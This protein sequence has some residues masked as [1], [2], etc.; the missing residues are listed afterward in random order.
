MTQYR[1]SIPENSFNLKG[2]YGN[3][4]YDTRNNLTAYLNY[5]VSFLRGPHWLSNG[6]QLN[7]LLSF[8]GGQP[9]SVLTG[10]DSSGTNEGA[11]RATQVGNPV[12][13]VNRSLVKGAGSLQWITSNAFTTPTNAYGLLAR[14]SLYG[15]GFGDVDLSVFKTGH[16]TEHVTAQFRAE[17]FN[18]FNRTN[19]A[20]IDNSL[21]D[22]SSFGTINTTIGN[23]NGAPGIG[24][25][26]PYNTQF[27]L[28]VLF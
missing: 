19:L 17:M 4:D 3:M 8:H 1:N 21:G 22:G 23:Y 20:P 13:G 27:A 26:E 7:S 9:Y 2:D 25:G 28:K 10:V 5:D 15:P 16:I 14:N 12:A 24:P 11:D 6:W 18:I